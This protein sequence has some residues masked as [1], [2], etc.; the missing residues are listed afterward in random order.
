MIRSA[1]VGTAGW[2]LWMR[3]W[4]SGRAVL[5]LIVPWAAEA[6]TTAKASPTP[7]SRDKRVFINASIYFYLLK[8][9]TQTSPPVFIGYALKEYERKGFLPTSRGFSQVVKHEAVPRPP[10]AS[11]VEAALVKG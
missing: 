2:L 5:G 4:R 8:T 9:W 3:A 7:E 11:G 6:E 1:G 10:E